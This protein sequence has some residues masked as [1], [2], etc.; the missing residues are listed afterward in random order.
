VLRFG[1]LYHQANPV[2]FLEVTF[3]NLRPGGYLPWRRK[4]TLL[5]GSNIRYFITRS[6][7]IDLILGF[8]Y[9]CADSIWRSRASAKFENQSMSCPYKD[10]CK[11]HRITL[12][13]R[14]SDWLPAHS[15]ADRIRRSRRI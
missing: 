9:G 1:V 13:A 15:W 11:T 10:L 5:E 8:E 3:D 6:T 4:Y 14:K 2:R 7:L 12:V